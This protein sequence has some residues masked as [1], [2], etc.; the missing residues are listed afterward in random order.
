MVIPPVVV[1]VMVMTVP[2]EIAKDEE[3]TESEPSPPEWI[4]DPA[5]KI[6]VFPWGRIIT[7]NG[8]SVLFII[9]LHV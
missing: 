6:A 1:P 3:T 7:H 2:V 4:G 5:V 8:R 9:L